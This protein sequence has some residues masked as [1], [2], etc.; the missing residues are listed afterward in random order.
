[1][2][3]KSSIPLYFGDYIERLISSPSTFSKLQSDV[4]R[5][6]KADVAIPIW[7]SPHFTS[8]TQSCPS[9][10]LF[11]SW[12]GTFIPFFI[13]IHLNAY[14]KAWIGRSKVAHPC[15]PINDSVLY[16]SFIFN[17]LLHSFS[18]RLHVRR[19]G[20]DDSMSASGSAGPGFNPPARSR[21]L[22][23]KFSTSG[24]GG[25]EMYTFYSLDCTSQ[26]WIKFQTPPQ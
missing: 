23:W 12:L 4:L 26:S 24:R 18:C 10:F 8:I 2:E 9:F 5:L 17:V 3:A 25:V 6:R 7:L 20:S 1:M 21:I 14:C 13:L 19:V 11:L 15:L 16:L 22:I